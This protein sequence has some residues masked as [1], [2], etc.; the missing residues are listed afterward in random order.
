MSEQNKSI[1]SLIDT[2]ETAHVT[3]NMPL[4]HVLLKR[5]EEI[6]ENDNTSV[7]KYSSKIMKCIIHAMSYTD[8]DNI[9]LQAM[10]CLSFVIPFI[11]NNM[12]NKKERDIICQIVLSGSSNQINKKLRLYS[13][14]CITKIIKS[15]YNMC[16]SCSGNFMQSVIQISK[17]CIQQSINTSDPQ[18]QTITQQAIE[19]FST[20]AKIEYELITKTKNI[21]SLIAVNARIQHTQFVNQCLKSMVPIYLSALLTQ[22]EPFDEDEWTIRKAAACSL[23]LFASVAKDNI[24]KYVLSF[25]YENIT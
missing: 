5:M 1:L 9:N 23:E 11:K 25:V 7:I 24:L 22:K 15:Y 3:K 16:R 19:V 14:T 17:K 18:D 20:I 6:C 13:F 4:I 21:C 8:Q 12:N 10:K 2:F